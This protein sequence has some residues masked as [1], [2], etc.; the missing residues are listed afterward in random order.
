M[1]YEVM[2]RLAAGLLL[3]L[4]CACAG[5]RPVGDVTP[6]V[7]PPPPAEP[8]FAYEGTLRSSKDVEQ[9]STRDRIKR[10]AT[11]ATPRQVGLEKPYGVAA[12]GGR[13]YITDTQQRAIHM[14]D[15]AARRFK[16]FGTEGPGSVMKPLGITI[17]HTGDVYVADI[18]AQRVVVY[19]RDGNFLRAIG[20]ARDLKRP[21]G[22]A[23][24]GDGG[25]LYVVDT[26]GV[27]SE[28]HRIAVYDTRTGDLLRTI[29][30]RGTAP[31][32]M[33][34]P[35][36]AATSADGRLYVVD[37]GNFR[38]QSFDE[39]GQVITTI[40]TIGRSGGQFSRPKGIAVDRD[41]NVYVVD[42]AFGN[43]Q[44]FN[45]HG[46]LLLHVGDRATASGPAHFMLPAGIAVDEHGR[47]YVV[48][49]FFAKVDVFR[50]V[51]L[52]ALGTLPPF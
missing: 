5:P 42:T 18:S 3:A 24:S 4:L 23:L 50:P 35:L 21:S 7:F 17:S 19:D 25:W 20:D 32:D 48:D 44:V 13:V 31:G 15:L 28:Q 49:Q 52:P 11:G 6:P 27:D 10:L 37:A 12:K 38:V 39:N 47:I 1:P 34:L 8:R 51:G 29:G 46:E 43:F 40:G 33:N 26:G 16:L 45:A 2:R 22:V 30:K 9:L 36:Q 14:F 41:G